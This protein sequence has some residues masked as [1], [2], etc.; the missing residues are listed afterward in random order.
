MSKCN[1]EKWWHINCWGWPE[2]ALDA[3]L[4]GLFSMFKSVIIEWKNL[5]R[6]GGENE[7]REKVFW[8]QMFA[9]LIFWFL[10]FIYNDFLTLV[11]VWIFWLIFYIIF[12]NIVSLKLSSV[13]LM[14]HVRCSEICWLY[15]PFH[16]CFVDRPSHL[17]DTLG[18]GMLSYVE[19]I[20][21]SFIAFLLN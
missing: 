18:H 13:V 16:L 20:I 2:V 1:G 4:M 7:S 5:L 3:S 6:G 17:R 9:Y 14:F 19:R 11:M 15:F 10:E 12:I 8:V 21:W